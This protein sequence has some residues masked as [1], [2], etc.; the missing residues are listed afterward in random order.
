MRIPGSNSKLRQNSVELVKF[1]AALGYLVV[2]ASARPSVMKHIVSSWLDIHG[3]PHSVC[4][5]V[6]G[7]HTLDKSMSLK[8]KM[9]ENFSHS[10]NVSF[11]AAYGSQKDV[12][13]YSTL[14]VE[15]D[16]TFI[17]PD[18]MTS[19]G[20]YSQSG[21]FVTIPRQGIPTHL[22]ELKMTSQEITAES[23]LSFA[24]QSTRR[25]IS[26]KKFSA[27][28][29]N[30]SLQRS[31][32]RNLPVNE[33]SNNEGELPRNTQQGV[34]NTGKISKIRESL[35]GSKKGTSSSDAPPTRQLSKKK[36]LTVDAINVKAANTSSF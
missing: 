14:G 32:S 31:F 6:E 25:T 10:C 2:Y 26:S 27:S 34:A 1:W 3:F 11:Y 15:P 22:A 13:M 21:K 7:L 4:F 5:F 33:W 9:L 28:Q 17:F 20:K 18:R 30:H 16:R 23:P 35:S 36:S 8:L 24:M 29:L 12:H 19:S